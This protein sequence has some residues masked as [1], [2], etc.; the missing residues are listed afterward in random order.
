MNFYKFLQV[1][2]G[3]L[4]FLSTPIITKATVLYLMPQSEDVYKG[5]SFI[6]ELMIDT[7]GE[8]IN[9]TDVK[10][11]FPDNLIEINDFEK[12][13]SIF[14]LWPEEPNI[15]KGL[16]S[17]SAGVPGGFSGKG[18]IGRINFSGKDIGEAEINFK[19]DSKVLLNDGKGSPAML[20]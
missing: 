3:I 6:A 13:G 18:L 12:G 5:E 19:E 4:L 11:I 16:I 10:L 17:F 7:E 2:L 9:T 20:G 14:T 8:E 15:K 1:S